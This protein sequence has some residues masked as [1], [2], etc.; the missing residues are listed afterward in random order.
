[1]ARGTKCAEIVGAKEDTHARRRSE[2]VAW[3]RSRALIFT[4]HHG[5]DIT[6]RIQHIGQRAKPD[7]L[8][9]RV[10]GE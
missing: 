7:V 2:V 6:Y 4:L 9:I 3:S 8:V 10:I 1:M 5:Q